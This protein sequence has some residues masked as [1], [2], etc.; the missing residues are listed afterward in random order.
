MQASRSDC[1]FKKRTFLEVGASSR[2]RPS[3][4]A[5]VNKNYLRARTFP[6]TSCSEDWKNSKHKYYWVEHSLRRT[7]SVLYCVWLHFSGLQAVMN[8]N[9]WNNLLIKREKVCGRSNCAPGGECRS[10]NDKKN[11]TRMKRGFAS[12]IQFFGNVLNRRLKKS[13]KYSGIYC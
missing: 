1:L 13:G 10:S 12:L 4:S 7:L 2:A 9:D 11:K 6:S 3:F 8:N 5:F